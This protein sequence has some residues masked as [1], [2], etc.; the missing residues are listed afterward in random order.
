MI[1]LR[2]MS[3]A[4]F[5]EY[6]DLAVELL[7]QEQAEAFERPVEEMQLSARKAFA[8]LLPGGGSVGPDQHLFSLWDGDKSLGYAWMSLRGE[9]KQAAYVLD[10]YLHPE[11]RGQGLGAAAFVAI[12]NRA[13]Q[14]GA[15]TIFLSV[16]RQNTIAKHLYE[17]LGFK[18][19]S[20]MMA[21]P[22]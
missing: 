15:E 3:A 13:R 16:F 6:H 1:E 9:R 7:A 11:M 17:K 12:E 20:Y 8:S 4:E 22:L 21:K 2:D 18:I 10:F 5:V 14:L 19:V